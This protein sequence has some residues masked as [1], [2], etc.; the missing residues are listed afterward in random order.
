[1]LGTTNTTNAGKEKKLR[2]PLSMESV[3][4]LARTGAGI[5][6]PTLVPI[7]LCTSHLVACEGRTSR[8]YAVM[9]AVFAVGIECCA[10]VNPVLPWVAVVPVVLFT[11]TGFA[12]ECVCAA[13]NAAVRRPPIR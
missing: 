8:D 5:H 6:W 10:A 13:R 3:N 4:L 11:V 1:M 2:T 9:C 7:V 12:V